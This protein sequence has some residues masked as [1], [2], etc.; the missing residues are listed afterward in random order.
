VDS[1]RVLTAMALMIAGL[2][3]AW[4]FTVSSPSLYAACVV[5]IVFIYGGKLAF[6]C[7]H[8]MRAHYT[9]TGGDHC[10]SFS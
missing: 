7:C 3:M 8:R 6:P 4:S 10:P 1:F 5:G 9:Y 2:L